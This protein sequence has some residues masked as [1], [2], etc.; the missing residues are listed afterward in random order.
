MTKYWIFLHHKCASQY[1]RAQ[2]SAAGQHAK[3]LTEIPALNSFPDPP[4][5]E[6]MIYA[7]SRSDYC[8]DDNAWPESVR[9]LDLAH[10]VDWRAVHFTRDPRDLLVSAYFS[11]KHSHGLHSVP[12]LR[13]HREALCS[14]GIETGLL[15][16]MD[17]YLT[18]QAIRSILTWPKKHPKVTTLDA[19]ALAS[20]MAVGDYALFRYA[21]DWIDIPVGPEFAA[22]TWETISDGRQVDEELNTH[23]YRHGVQGDWRRYFTAAVTQEFAR[24]YGTEPA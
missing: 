18:D 7:M 23:H 9:I 10:P 20:Q 14:T 5:P 24:R 15:M 21:T 8:L 3:R 4:K 12:G 13:A 11:H 1:L 2:V 17:F 16:E 6:S 22:P 19:I